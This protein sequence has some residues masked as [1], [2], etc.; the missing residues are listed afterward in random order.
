MTVK[1]NLLGVQCEVGSQQAACVS[2]VVVVHFIHVV[3][4]VP[5]LHVYSTVGH[6]LPLDTFS[7]GGG[8]GGVM[9]GGS[10]HNTC[11]L[12]IMWE[13]VNDILIMNQWWSVC[14]RVGHYFHMQLYLL[15]ILYIYC[16]YSMRWRTFASVCRCKHLP[17]P[18][19]SRRR[20]GPEAQW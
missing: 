13:W 4:R 19:R 12:L 11:T 17:P 10:R 8:G 20:A 2:V 18:S 15:Y 5:D 1:V 6:G 16:I 9:R 7:P 14:H 3:W